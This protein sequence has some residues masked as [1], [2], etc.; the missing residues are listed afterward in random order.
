MAEKTEIEL[1]RD[2]IEH[3]RRE[4]VAAR[5]MLR[6]DYWFWQGDGED[7]LE[8]LS[9]PV[10]IRPEDLAALIGET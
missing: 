6:G 1:L 2:E 8:S 3:L 9:C 4:L 5:D 10:V 7:H